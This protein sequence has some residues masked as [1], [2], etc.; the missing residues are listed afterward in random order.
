MRL[1]ALHRKTALRNFNSAAHVEEPETEILLQP[2]V[3]R[4]ARAV[5]PETEKI[6]LTVS[7]LAE[8][9]ELWTGI[10]A[11]K[12][13]E[14]EYDKIENLEKILREKIV[15]QEEATELVAKAIRFSSAALRAKKRSASFIFVGPTGV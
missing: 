7:D 14:N 2:G 10:K 12:I 6:E 9:I 8:V 1:P 11:S 5:L 4:V 13:Q 15:G 3:G